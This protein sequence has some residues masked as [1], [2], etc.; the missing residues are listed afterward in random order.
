MKI[1]QLNIHK[2]TIEELEAK[3]GDPSMVLAAI[4]SFKNTLSGQL[5][6]A[7]KGAQFEADARLLISK[8]QALALHW[9]IEEG[10]ASE[11]I[12]LLESKAAIQAVRSPGL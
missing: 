6:F 5:K 1:N 9:R 4:R 7:F 11:R 2:A 10:S 3:A 8:R 12:V